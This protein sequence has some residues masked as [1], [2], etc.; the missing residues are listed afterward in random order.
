MDREEVNIQRIIGKQQMLVDIIH[1]EN[2][3]ARKGGFPFVSKD[4]LAKW[5]SIEKEELSDFIDVCSNL[6]P[7]NLARNVA[8]ECALYGEEYKREE[9]AFR[10]MMHSFLRFGEIIL[11]LVYIDEISSFCEGIA[12]GNFEA[13]Q[14]KMEE[15]PVTEKYSE[16]VVFEGIMKHY[17]EHFIEVVKDAESKGYDWDVINRMLRFEISSERFHELEEAFA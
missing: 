4:E 17:I 5:A 1:Y 9:N 3:M 6:D 2:D 8:H 14:A 16:G 15:Y 12:K 11:E 7:F 13:Y 10:F